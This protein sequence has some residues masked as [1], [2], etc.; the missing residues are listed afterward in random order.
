MA[1]FNWRGYTSLGDMWQDWHEGKFEIEDEDLE[2][3]RPYIWERIRTGTITKDES[4]LFVADEDDMMLAY[5]DMVHVDIVDLSSI[6]HTEL[7]IYRDPFTDEPHY[8]GTTCLCVND[9]CIEECYH[10]LVPY[11]RVMREAFEPM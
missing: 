5:D 10:R 11:K 8:Y 9:G 7:R 2:Y 4:D 3:L 1:D 6:N